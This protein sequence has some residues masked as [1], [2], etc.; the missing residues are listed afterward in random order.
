MATQKIQVQ[1]PSPI[2]FS[3]GDVQIPIAGK[4]CE[5]IVAELHGKYYTQTYRG[6]LFHGSTAAA[7]VLLPAVTGTAVTFGLWNPIGSGRNAVLVKSTIGYIS[8]TGAAGNIVY[9]FQSGVGATAA[10]GAPITA[11]TLGTAQS[12]FLGGGTKS[13]MNFIPATA[14]LA[15][16]NTLLRPMGISQL[17]TTATTT[18]NIFSQA[19]DDLDGSIVVPP[20]TI[21]SIQGNIA[22]L[23]VFNIGLVW[24][25]APQ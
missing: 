12:G 19:V 22:L 11:A 7:G 1:A 2:S 23:S 18:S 25:E 6:N 8:T 13:A 16:A 9:S 21:F 4:Q 20:G 14:T 15:A 5:A 17:V 10:T 3:D 24:Y